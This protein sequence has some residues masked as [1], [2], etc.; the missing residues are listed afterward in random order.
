VGKIAIYN[1]STSKLHIFFKN[2]DANASRRGYDYQALK[3]VETWVENF[4]NEVDQP[5]SYLN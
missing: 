1:M 5:T 3:T 2:T 4:I